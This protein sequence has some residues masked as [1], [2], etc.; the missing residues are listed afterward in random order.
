M[1]IK[2]VAVLVLLLH[3]LEKT[4]IPFIKKIILPATKRIGADF[5]EFAAPEIGKVVI[6][7]KKRKTFAKDVGKKTARKHLGGG[8]TS[9]SRRISKIRPTF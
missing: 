9:P 5:F 4:Q 8:K 7:L 2:M 6:G 1:Q 3:F